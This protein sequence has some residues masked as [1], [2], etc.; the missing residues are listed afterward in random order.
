MSRGRP[1]PTGLE[2]TV[3]EVSI[4]PKRGTQSPY[5][6]LAHAGVELLAKHITRNPLNGTKLVF[7][8]TS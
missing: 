1:I 7:V 2:L 4:R 8:P 5:L 6:E 3:A